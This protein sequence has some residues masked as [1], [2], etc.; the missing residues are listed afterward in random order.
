MGR[1]KKDEDNLKPIVQKWGER[2]NDITIMCIFVIQLPCHQIEN[3]FDFL[4]KLQGFDDKRDSFQKRMTIFFTKYISKKFDLFPSARKIVDKIKE[5]EE[6]KR[7]LDEIFCQR[8][9]NVIN[10]T[11][12][13]LWAMTN[14]ELVKV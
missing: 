14:E 8:M 2:N 9:N 10:E 12:H 5:K 7:E 4:N 3:I 1:N 11:G 6:W 13:L